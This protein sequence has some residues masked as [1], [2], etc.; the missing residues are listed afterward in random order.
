MH[1]EPLQTAE[2][3]AAILDRP[4]ATGFLGRWW[5]LLALAIMSLLLIRACI[6]AAPPAAPKFDAAALAQ[7]ANAKALAALS[8]LTTDAPLARV[9]AALNLP[10]VNFAVGSARIPAD[11]EPVLAKVA[12]VIAALPESAHLE[13]GGHTDDT[14]TTDGNLVL[15]QK[16]A[17]SVLA[18][19]VGRGVA[20]ERLNAKGYGAAMPTTTNATE[21]GRFRNRRIEFVLLR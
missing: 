11:A 10:V 7:E 21:Q 5:P 4:E 14:G 13:I 20:V 16:R 3:A 1:S 12:E 9:I 15:S 8:A 19:L 2:D 17:E 6:S 18:F